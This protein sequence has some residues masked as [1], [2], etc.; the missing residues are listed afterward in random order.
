MT[1]ALPGALL[2]AGLALQPACAP[3]AGAGAVAELRAADL[4]AADA[5]H[6]AWGVGSLRV[7]RGT[8]AAWLELTTAG[9]GAPSL[10]RNVRAFDPPVDLGERF[11]RFEIRVDRVEHLAG[12]ELRLLSG[13]DGEDFFAYTVP[14]Y[15]DPAFNL[16]QSDT[17]APVT[18][19]LGNARRV[20]TPDP[21]AIDG[22][23]LYVADRGER[24]VRLAWRSVSLVELP[25]HGVVSLTFD[26]GYAEHYGVAAPVMEQHGMAGTAYVMPDQLGD[27]GYMTEVEVR[28]LHERFGWDVGAHHATPFTD[29]APDALART[30]ADVRGALS[31]LDVGGG[32][33]HLAFPLGKHDSRVVMPLVRAE[34]TTSRIAGGGAET[35]P[36]ADPHKLRVVDVKSTTP[37][38][39]VGRLAARAHAHREWLILMFHRLVPEPANELQY[40][41]DDFERAVEAID[42]S[43]V[44]VQPVTQVWESLGRRPRRLVPGFAARSQ[45]MDPTPAAA[46]P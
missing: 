42:R 6:D 21:A 14:L 38:D 35:L 44:R 46:A 5:Y 25:P 37:P 33:Q 7:A 9:N 26:D 2:C 22:I 40:G 32:F 23:A 3:D 18:F 16:L 45:R 34:F 39:E 12:A 8:E 24:P 4:T 36:P 30:V 19:T 10:V 11:V 17:W 13:T 28:A 27:A 29:F 41:V 15:G 31:A 1:R 43:G 20:G